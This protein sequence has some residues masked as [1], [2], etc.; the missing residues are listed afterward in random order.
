VLTY[1]CLANIYATPQVGESAS[2]REGGRRETVRMRGGGE[3]DF[4]ATPLGL[5]LGL[6]T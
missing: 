1:N 5:A 4:H 6:H 3:R 2:K